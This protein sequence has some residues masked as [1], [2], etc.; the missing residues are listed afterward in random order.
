MK[1][2][3]EIKPFVTQEKPTELSFVSRPDGRRQ[4]RKSIGDD[5]LLDVSSIAPNT[6][7]NEM[8]T[9]D[10]IKQA[11]LDYEQ[12]NVTVSAGNTT[13]T[14]TV[15]S[16]STVFGYRPTGNQDQ[17]IDNISISATTLTVTL[18]AAATADNT[19]QITLLKP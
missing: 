3:L 12:V 14:A 13:G 10:S 8:M 9:N 6:I 11:E 5:K 17:F 1:P 4:R 16:G 7:T 18:A 15:T 2:Q 19:F